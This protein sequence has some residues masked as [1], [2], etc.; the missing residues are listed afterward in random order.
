LE[1][2][3]HT[4]QVGCIVTNLQALETVL[5]RFLL[6]LYNQ[7]LEF[8]K[9]DDKEAKETYLTKYV[10]LGPL[11]NEFN[12]ARNEDEKRNLRSILKLSKFEMRLHTVAF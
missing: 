4:H 9:P 5:R 8:P 7:Q 2:K 1:W 6:S 12:A 11:V 3:D 10:S